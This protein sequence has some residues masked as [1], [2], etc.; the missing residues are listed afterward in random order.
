MKIFA[1]A[2]A[3]LAAW[4]IAPLA[5]AGDAPLEMAPAETLARAEGADEPAPGDVPP[6]PDSES[7]PAESAPAAE[8]ELSDTTPEADSSEA[9]IGA[10]ACIR[11]IPARKVW[12]ERT[13]VVPACTKTTSTP[14]SPDSM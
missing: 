8:K 1:Y 12:D 5:Y 13:I 7:A 3:A 9:P 11:T 4:L 2:A 14:G 6:T 10:I